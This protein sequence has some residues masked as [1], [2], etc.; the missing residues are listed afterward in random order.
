MKAKKLR[1]FNT[2]E[3]VPTVEDVIRS[4]NVLIYDVAEW[5]RALDLCQGIYQRDLVCGIESLSGRTLTGTR[6]LN[7]KRC[8][9][10]RDAL[11]R[12]LRVHRVDF[13][14]VRLSKRRVLMF[15]QAPESLHVQEWKPLR[16]IDHQPL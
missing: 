16:T 2:P 7:Y 8:K 9:A 11:L 5:Y 14:D 1:R 13:S 6:S 15:G 10:S 3:S 4:G 12:R